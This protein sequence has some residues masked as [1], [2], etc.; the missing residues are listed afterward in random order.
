[1][2]SVAC[3][4]YVNGDD[5]AAH[6]RVIRYFLEHN[7]I[8]KTKSGRLCNISFKY[9]YQTREEKYGDAFRPEITLA[10]F[11]DLET[12]AWKD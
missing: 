2:K 12:G 4:F 8:Q 9:D 7:L 10:D 3:V 1:M 6:K 11:L 5:R